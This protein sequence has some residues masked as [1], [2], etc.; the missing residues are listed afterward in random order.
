MGNTSIKRVRASY[1]SDCVKPI[2][3]IQKCRYAH[4]NKSNGIEQM[5]RY[6]YILR[7]VITLFYYLVLSGAVGPY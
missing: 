3:H 1:F 2:F 5:F 4:R 6:H 7:I